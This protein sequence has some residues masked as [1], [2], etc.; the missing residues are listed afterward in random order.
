MGLSIV[1]WSRVRDEI[2]KYVEQHPDCGIQDIV[3]ATEEAYEDIADVIEAMVDTGRL[4]RWWHGQMPTYYI[5]R[6]YIPMPIK[7]SEGNDEAKGHYGDETV[8]RYICPSCGTIITEEERQELLESQG[9]DFCYC[10][11]VVM[12]DDGEPIYQ[13]VLNRFQP[14]DESEYCTHGEIIASMLLDANRNPGDVNPH[15]DG[16]YIIQLAEQIKSERRRHG[17][18]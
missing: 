3:T 9:N 5:P 15:E 1:G 18:M 4:E 8:K 7:S 16:N 10:E 13:R 6:T 2:L 17:D 14:L 12:G 11:Y